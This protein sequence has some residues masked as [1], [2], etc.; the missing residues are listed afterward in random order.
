MNWAGVMVAAGV[1][2]ASMAWMP[3]SLP[4]LAGLVWVWWRS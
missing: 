1:V 2:A 4:L 3:Y